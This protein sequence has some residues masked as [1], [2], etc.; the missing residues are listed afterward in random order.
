MVANAHLE[1]AQGAEA[2][3]SMARPMFVLAAAV[4]PFAC[5]P[6]LWPIPNENVAADHSHMRA[7]P[8]GTGLPC[9]PP[10]WSSVELLWRIHAIATIADVSISF[11]R[12]P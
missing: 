2:V 6:C 1:G 7:K 12:P 5:A 10:P 3:G 4:V 8:V 9:S 11:Q